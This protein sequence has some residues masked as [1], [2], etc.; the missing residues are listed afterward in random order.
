[1]VV[2]KMIV[3]SPVFADD[4]KKGDESIGVIISRMRTAAIDNIFVNRSGLGETGE[5]YIVSDQFLMLSESRF[6]ENAVYQQKVDTLGVQKCFNEGEEYLGF[7]PDYRDIPIYGSSY[8]ADDLG[9]V[10]L[11]EN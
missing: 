11:V 3:I 6:F 10:L 7:Y 9:I 1:M 4:S 8:C 5:V 2:K